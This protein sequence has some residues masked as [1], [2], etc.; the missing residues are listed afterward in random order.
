VL[1]IVVFYLFTY[2][3][4]RHFIKNALEPKWFFKSDPPPLWAPH[5]PPPP[6]DYSNVRSNGQHC[7]L[8]PGHYTQ[9]PEI[10]VQVNPFRVVGGRGGSFWQIPSL[11]Q[12]SNLIYYLWPTSVITNRINLV[13]GWSF[14]YNK[15]FL[16]QG[17]KKV[18]K[19]PSHQ[20]RFAW[21]WYGSL[22]PG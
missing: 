6:P 18:L 22:G 2:F 12:T 7:P 9:L 21:K 13:Q 17:S 3:L 20:I 19:G 10:L 16:A 8:P 11:I 5:T 15:C 14:F 1:K 4:A